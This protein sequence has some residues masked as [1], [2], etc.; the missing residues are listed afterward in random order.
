[1]VGLVPD[2]GSDMVLPAGPRLR[3]QLPRENFVTRRSER[4]VSDPY[5]CRRALRR[6]CLLCG[7]GPAIVAG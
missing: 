2:T 3:L 6:R 4:L 5:T 1:M 7:P